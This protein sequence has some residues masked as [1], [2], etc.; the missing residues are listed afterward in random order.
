MEIKYLKLDFLCSLSPFFLLCSPGPVFFHGILHRVQIF[1]VF[2]LFPC[3]LFF[4]FLWVLLFLFNFFRISD[5]HRV[6]QILLLLLG[7]R[8]DFHVT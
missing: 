6:L 1:I 5:L 3:R 4:F 2:F 7:K 8:L